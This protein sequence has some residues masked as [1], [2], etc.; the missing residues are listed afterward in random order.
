MAS[1][2]PSWQRTLGALAAFAVLV[3]GIGGGLSYVLRDHGLQAAANWAQLV[4]IPLALLPLIGQLFRWWRQSAGPAVAT[5]TPDEMDQ[6]QRKLATQVLSQ[7]TEEIRI[8][9]L[10]DPKPLVVHWRLTGL[11]VMYHV[12]QI[13][14][15]TLLRGLPGREQLRFSGRTDG[16]DKMVSEFRHLTRRRLVILGARRIGK[17]PLPVLLLPEL[18][19]HPQPGDPVPVLLTISGWDPTTEPLDRWIAR[20]LGELYPALRAAAYGPDAP[21]ALVTERPSRILPILDGLDELP[22]QI[23]PQVLTALSKS[24]TNADG[25]ILTCRTAEFQAA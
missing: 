2:R 11:N 3:V 6:A 16:I 21:W 9:E 12:G 25:L 7:W 17:T 5:S 14:R 15:P 20:R 8:R 19:T 22:K 10:D 1:G 24:M 18:L 23:H 13:V 4:S